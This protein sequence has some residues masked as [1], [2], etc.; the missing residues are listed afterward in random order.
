MNNPDIKSLNDVS[1]EIT[2]NKVNFFE[3]LEE[4]LLKILIKIMKKLKEIS[5]WGN[6]DFINIIPLLNL[7]EKPLNNPLD[8]Q[9]FS[10]FTVYFLNKRLRNMSFEASFLRKISR[11]TEDSIINLSDIKRKTQ[12]LG[13][14][15]Y[16]DQSFQWLP[17]DII[18][19][20]LKKEFLRKI[21]YNFDWENKQNYENFT[22]IFKKF[23]QEIFIKKPN[24][25]IF[26]RKHDLRN[27]QI[28]IKIE[29]FLPKFKKHQWKEIMD[30]KEEKIGESIFK[31]LKKD[32]LVVARK[33]TIDER[34]KV[35]RKPGKRVLSYLAK[36][37]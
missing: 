6:H 37:E 32:N 1:H 20:F 11:K 24:E 23:Q 10:L 34:K 14:Y 22:V 31:E 7:L 9:N 36:N 30:V 29:E 2:I 8:L 25:L 5:F 26:L 19:S 4:I 15:R 3:P 17:L 12:A 13:I 16:S 27:M 28:P 35:Q 18:H 21:P 33:L